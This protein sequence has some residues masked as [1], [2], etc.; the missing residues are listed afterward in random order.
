MLDEREGEAVDVA[1]TPDGELWVAMN[2]R[3]AANKWRPRIVLLDAAGQDT[4]IE[5]P[6]ESGQ[7]V[8][9][10][11]HD[12]TGGCF[13][14]GFAGTGLGDTDVVVWRMTGE[15]VPVFSGKAWDYWPDLMLPSHSFTDI[16]TDVVVQ[17]GVAWVVGMSY[18]KHDGP[19][20]MRTRGLIVR[21]DVDTGAV[22]GPAIIAPNA[23]LWTQS[24]WYGAAAHPNGVLVTGTGCNDACDE[25]RVE[26][27][28]YTA[29]GWRAW[30]RPETSAVI[31]R[32]NAVAVGAHNVVVVAA[33]VKEG[34]TLRGHLFGRVLYSDSETF[35]APFPTGNEPSEATGTAVGP[36]DRIYGAGYRTFGG[37]Q[38]ARAVHLHP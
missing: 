28:L 21:M 3:E 37:I 2:V 27:A 22:L 38:E 29:E 36:F 7:T 6:T 10:I 31:A 32:G 33:T 15:G 30:F 8:T 1:V 24:M 4:G 16:A 19:L 13:A 5:A 12:G 9:G 14:S 26:T 34:A 17:D 35:S 18:G 23:N 25:Q 11:D 20:P